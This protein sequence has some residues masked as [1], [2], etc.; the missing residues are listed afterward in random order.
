[1]D[2]FDF[3][4][5]GAGT[6]GCGV[7]YRLA[8]RGHSVCVL[9]AGPSDTNPFIRIPSGI[10]KPSHDERITWRYLMRGNENIK[11]RD[12]PVY[13]GKTLGGSSAI[14]GMVYNR[15]Q[16][17]DFD[18][19]AAAGAEGW[20]YNSV[21]PYFRKTESY[22][23]G[24][25]DQFRGRHGPVPIEK[26]KVQEPLSDRFIR[27]AIE[28]G[29]SLNEDYNGR[30]QEGV[31][32]V[33]SWIHKGK[34]WG[35]AHAYLHPARRRF[36]ID[37]RTESLARRVVIEDRRAT[38][39]EYL[40][41]GSSRVETVNARLSVIV[42]AGTYV[43]PKLLQLSG[44]GPAKILQG[45]RIPVVL[46]LSGVGENLSDHY[47]VRLVARIKSGLGSLNERASGIPL[48]IEAMKYFLGRPSALAYTSMS[49]FTFNKLDP[50]SPDTEYSLMFVPCATKDGMVRQMADYPGA[51][52]GAWRQRP[53][54]RGYVR[55][56][57]ADINDPPII[58]PNY[59]D[60]EMDRKVTV[61]AM[62][63]L[64]AVFTS[65]AMAPIVEEFTLPSTECGSDEEWL[66]YCREF[67]VSSY[68]PA[69]TCKMG[70]ASDPSAVVDPRLRVRGISNLRVVDASVMP[71]QP[72]ANL[73]AAVMMIA[74]KAADMIAEDI[75][76]ARQG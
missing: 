43:S 51:T 39:V 23:D 21:L 55:I 18:N 15:G 45:Q 27:A 31:S 25:E 22:E 50:K 4:I 29:M 7:A 35:S 66:D 58:C 40:R 68:H 16:R 71:T 17:S 38:G 72:S 12:L 9:E 75:A 54:S 5:V 65:K 61:T 64:H 69:G 73:N 26:L 52:G 70:A 56:Q 13:T 20:G 14:N 3:V 48:L 63:H 2:T 6:G 42:S 37:V 11:G 44:I 33:Q 53:D 49:V 76:S 60:T 57:S 1:M 74:E 24:G 8:E 41:R 34:R 47:S 19:W 67:G 36:G 10:M 32:Y 28:T 59:L 62:K 46:D 30:E